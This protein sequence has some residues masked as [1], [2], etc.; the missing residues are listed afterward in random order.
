M[1]YLV[2][3]ICAGLNAWGGYSWHNAR[4]FIM[5]VVIAVAVSIILNTWWEG[6]LSIPFLSITLKTKFIGF[7]CLL[8]ISPLCAG[9]GEKSLIWKYFNDAWGRFAWMITVSIAFCLGLIFLNHLNVFI[10]LGYIIGNGII[11]MTLRKYN[12]ILTDALFGVT[13]SSFIF[14]IY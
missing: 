3:A 5:P 9:Y 7:P 11:G 10:A 13:L 6:T 12:Q 14:F 4:R 2:M 1:I 8:A